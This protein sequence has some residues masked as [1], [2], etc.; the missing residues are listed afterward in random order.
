MKLRLCICFVFLVF[1]SL[2]SS[3][4]C[5]SD[6][7]F[8]FGMKIFA[9]TPSLMATVATRPAGFAGLEKE[10]QNTSLAK[11]FKQP[12]G[13]DMQCRGYEVESEKIY[14]STSRPR[15]LKT[16]SAIAHTIQSLTR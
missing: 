5:C 7:T 10:L 8:H 13:E 6:G 4:V 16:S 1:L 9:S 14:V 15:A 3:N 12:D 11:L 2:F